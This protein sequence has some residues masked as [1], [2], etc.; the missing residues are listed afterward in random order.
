M[1]TQDSQEPADSDQKDPCYYIYDCCQK[2]DLECI[3]YCEPV[4]R[5][6]NNATNQI[7]GFKAFIET[8]ETKIIA[9]DCRKGYR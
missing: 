6:S 9:V 3:E 8:V 5:C 7:L 4:V 1:N 2:V